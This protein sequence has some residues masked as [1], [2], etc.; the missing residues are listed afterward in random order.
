V[1]PGRLRVTTRW[2]GRELLFFDISIPPN[3]TRSIPCLRCLR[4]S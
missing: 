1:A 2:F 4:A 3:N